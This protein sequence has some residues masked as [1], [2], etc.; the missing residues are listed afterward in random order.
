M[1]PM[2]KEL[3]SDWMA[4]CSHPPRLGK[5]KPVPSYIPVTLLLHYGKSLLHVCR[6]A[7][8]Y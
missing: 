3:A 8:Y 2:V 6:K 5:K 1:L 7:T 4:I